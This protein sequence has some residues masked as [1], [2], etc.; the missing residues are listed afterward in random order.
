M[1][2]ISKTGR[3]HPKVRLLYAGMY[4][5]LVLGGITMVYPFL[6]M[7]SGST[8]SAVDVKDFDVVPRFITDDAM[9]YRKHVEALFNERLDLLK[10]AYDEDTSSFEKLILPQNPNLTLVTLWREFL[11]QADL[12][13]TASALGNIRAHVSKTNP[14]M[15][16]KFKRELSGRYERNLSALNRDLGTEF[17][18]WDAFWVTPENYLVRHSSQQDDPFAL[19]FEEFKSRQPDACKTHFMIEGFYKALFLKTQYSKNIA[20]YNQSHGTDFKSYADVHL[21]QSFPGGTAQENADWEDFVRLSLNLLW[22]RIDNAAQTD[23][24]SYL[25]AKYVTVEKLNRNYGTQYAAFKDIPL[26]TQLPSQGLVL[27]DWDA[28]IGGWQDPDTDVIH[29]PALE[30]IQIDG[31]DFLFRKYLNSRFGTIA[32]LNT[33]LGSSYA[34]F[35]VVEVPL[36]DAHYLDFLGMRGSLRREFIVRN[37]ATVLDFL[38]LHG[39]GVL[40]TVIYCFLAVLSALIINPMAAYAMSR[41]RL[42]TTYKILVFMLLTMAF[43]PMVTQIP[44]FLMLRDFNLLN[45]FAALI[46]PG[47]AHGY[48]IFL[49]KGFFDSLPRE[50][51]ESAQIDGA[52]EWIMFWRITMSLSK[53]ILAVIAL[54]AFNMAYS[55]FMFALLFCQDQGMWT[56]MVWLFQLQAKSGQAVMYASLIIAAI[57]TFIVFAF[58]QNIIMR[59]IVVPVEK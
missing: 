8:K 45:T 1:P 19:A 43:P 23:Y 22:I 14:L 15:L 7:I 40:N 29:Q 27:T 34:N 37:Y 5:V 35:H 32:A 48:S 26:V 6:L 38:L 16:R 3:R 31:P 54:Q 9:L 42:P 17:P 18:S 59:G 50:Q 2:I 41:Y 44:V 4:T 55:N 53:P 51:Y 24:Q 30:H 39:R 58:C 33:H 57:P 20:D 56:L 13:S 36:K 49:L 12:P 52:G 46:L 21:S 25:R 28:F 10:A 47:M 11:A